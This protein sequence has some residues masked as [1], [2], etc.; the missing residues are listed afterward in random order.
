MDIRAYNK[1]NDEE[2]LMKLIEDEGEEWADYSS[3]SNSK[4]Y[5]TALNNSI[6]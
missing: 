2:K 3:E 5:K 1:D 6:T 4:K